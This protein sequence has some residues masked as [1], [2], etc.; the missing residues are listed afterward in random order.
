MIHFE[1]YIY[2]IP[3]LLSAIFAVR[4]LRQKWPQPFPAFAVFLVVTLCVEL[5]ATWWNVS[6]YKTAYW[7][8][9]PTNLWLYN[10]YLIPQYLFY[11]YY[12][13]TLLHSPRAR[14]AIGLAA[15]GYAL[16]GTVN[17]GWGQG[18]HTIDSYTIIL[19]Y[20]LV[21][22]CSILFFNQS[23]H[24][25]DVYKLSA[26]PAIWITAGM[27]FFH[28]CSLPCFIFANYLNVKDPVVSLSFFYAIQF[29]N[30]VM[31]TFYLIAFLCKPRSQK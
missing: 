10:F 31:Y 17:Y 11:L 7:Q 27:F 2:M 3:M 29:F 22:G 30:I 26:S 21:I 6:L 19:A 5:L 23:V 13:Y 16:L 12:F 24:T 15:I 20:L 25:Q 1:Y 14:R 9:K 28:F 4:T 8:Y 18:P